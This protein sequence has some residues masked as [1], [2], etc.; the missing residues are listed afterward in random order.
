MR[1][2]AILLVLLVLT[3]TPARAAAPDNDSAA[4]ATAVSVFPASIEA[5][6]SQAT[7]GPFEQDC[8]GQ[9][10]F[11]TTVHQPVRAVWYLL[12]LP[13]GTNYLDVTHD[14]GAEV[15][16]WQQISTAPT[17]DPI[18]SRFDCHDW[19]PPGLYPA[20]G[21]QVYMSVGSSVV[22]SGTSYSVTITPT[23]EYTPS[24][25]PND[26]PYRATKI[27]SLP[28]SIDQDATAAS[29]DY[30]PEGCPQGAYVWY[31]YTPAQSESIEIKVTSRDSFYGVTAS[32]Y[33][34]GDTV[35]TLGCDSADPGPAVIDTPVDAGVPVLIGVGPGA[36]I[37]LD[38]H[39][40]V[41]TH[42]SNPDARAD[43]TALPFGATLNFN[44]TAATLETGEPTS[45]GSGG[46]IWFALPSRPRGANVEFTG[47]ASVAAIAGDSVLACSTSGSLA[48]PAGSAATYLQVRSAGTSGTIGLRFEPGLGTQITGASPFGAGCGDP[49]GTSQLNSEVEVSQTVDPH[50]ANHL[51]VA[52]QQ[53]R[54][55]ER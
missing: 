53:D 39:E 13:E 40:I 19:Y 12:D 35:T 16:F 4:N 43:A 17:G 5:D 11:V 8:G 24:S 46:S 27:G 25:V 34:L 36:R 31:S 33:A 22:F 49:T 47:S 32:A 44:T 10:V 3:A 30:D 15:V 45:C 9:G 2:Y 37:S 7:T 42:G 54:Y 52:Y 29:F 51:I 20:H 6:T 18:L 38:V 26:V 41:P 48:I 55:T 28:Y 23:A 1:R 14:D 50:D 21:P